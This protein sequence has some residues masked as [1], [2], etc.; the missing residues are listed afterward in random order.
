VRLL[1]EHGARPKYHHS[2]VGT[3]SRLDALQAA[4][5]RVKLKH[6]DRWSEGR[7]RNAALY[8]QLF[9]GSRV[10]RPYRDPRARHIYN[11]Y[12]IRV[13]KR[14]QVRERVSERGIGTEVYYPG[15]LHLQTCFATLGHQEGDMPHAEAAARETLALP[16]YPELTEEQIR[17]VA[18]TVRDIMDQT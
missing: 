7:A 9:E 6:L 4:I 16:I 17:Y 10:G 13:P 5:L 11:Q 15:P 8:D 2:L 14:D 1:R 3:N 18:A 12:V